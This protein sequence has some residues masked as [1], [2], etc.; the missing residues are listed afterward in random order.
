[1]IN[2]RLL[3]V[4]KR[5]SA[6]PPIAYTLGHERQTPSSGVGASPPACG[7]TG[8]RRILH[9]GGRRVPRRRPPFG[10][11]LGQR[12]S[13]RGRAGPP[14]PLLPGA[15]AQVDVDPGEDRPPVADRQPGRARVRH[16]VVDRPTA[17]PTDPRGV[18]RT[19]QSEIPQCVAAGAGIHPAEAPARPPRT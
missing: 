18:R 1:K 19:T 13:A 7:P 4:R 9:R 16:R 3:R 14:L 15:T 8:P 2:T 12:V 5:M 17:H 6:P 10:P 11:T